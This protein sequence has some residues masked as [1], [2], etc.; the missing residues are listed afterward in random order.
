[1]AGL[2]GHRNGKGESV[3][4]VAEMVGRRGESAEE[5]AEEA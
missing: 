5:H 2:S 4:G 1:M 3:D